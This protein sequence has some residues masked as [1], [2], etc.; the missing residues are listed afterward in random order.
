MLTVTSRFNEII[1]SKE[2]DFR[3]R[4]L[5]GALYPVVVLDMSG[6]LLKR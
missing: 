6:P 2:R 4:T 5:K 3:T 1:Y